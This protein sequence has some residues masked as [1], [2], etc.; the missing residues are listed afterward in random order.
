MYRVLKITSSTDDEQ[1]EAKDSMAAATRSD[2]SA[3][4]LGALGGYEG[5]DVGDLG[6]LGGHGV[7]G[8]GDLVA[9]QRRRWW[10]EGFF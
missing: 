7:D 1:R 3:G 8:A 9:G 5:G 10:R 4:D 6:A 2:D